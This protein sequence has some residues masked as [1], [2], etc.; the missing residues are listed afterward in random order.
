MTLPSAPSATPAAG[1]IGDA[2]GSR[3]GDVIQPEPILGRRDVALIPWAV[4]A[5]VAIALAISEVLRDA[6][7][8]TL[9]PTVGACAAAALL[10]IGLAL[11]TDR[12]LFVPLRRSLVVYALGS[13]GLIVSLGLHAAFTLG[14]ESVLFTALV[15]HAAY[16]GLV[17]PRRWSAAFTVLMLVAAGAVQ[18]VEPRAD[19]LDALSVFGLITSGWAIGVL[20]GAAHRRAERVARRLTRCDPLTAT[21]N[22]RGFIEELEAMVHDSGAFTQPIALMILDLDGFKRINQQRGNAGGDELLAWIGG[23]L[24]A[25]LPP[26]AAAGRLGSDEFAVALLGA[27]RAQAVQ[28]A[29]R[30]R[31]AIDER[32]PVSIGIA[33]SEDG[34]VSAIDLLRVADAAMRRAKSDPQRVQSLIAGGFRR[35]SLGD[36]PVTHTP[37]SI[38]YDQLR[39]MGGRPTRPQSGIVFGWLI[40]GGFTVIGIAGAVVVGITIATGGDSFWEGVIKY[41]GPPWVLANLAV[42]ALNSGNLTASGLRF[43]FVFTAANALLGVGIG[44]AALAT[45]DGIAAP[46]IAGLYLKV[47]F[48]SAIGTKRQARITLATITAWWLL[49]VVLGPSRV[50]WAVPLEFTLLAS[51]YALGSI[52]RAALADTTTQWLRLARTD[53]L[54]GLANRAGFDEDCAV[55]LEQAR[56]AGSRVALLAFDLDGFKQTNETAGPAAGDVILQRVAEV[57]RTV[58]PDAIAAGRLG[59]DEFVAA[60]PIRSLEDADRLTV[61]VERAVGGILSTSAGCAVYP[62]DGAD[63]ETLVRAADLRCRAAKAV[64]ALPPNQ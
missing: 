43:R 18:A 10:G 56:V 49:T 48:D 31:A 45:G 16:I 1:N 59:G 28:L 6:G 13:T 41:L 11:T 50:L 36:R 64:K 32:H 57:V 22:R 42:A 58:L 37:P 9:I 53:V 25:T 5:A 23:A 12:P 62:D 29:D 17:L 26:H 33:S 3:S 4:T 40:R 19:L 63:V 47:A 55:G 35:V 60:V 34:M 39:S 2:P 54:T 20:S 51:A 8:G 46:V 44:A 7:D 30:L 61:T 21:L 27:D 38:T 24:G 15:L 52:S 14:L